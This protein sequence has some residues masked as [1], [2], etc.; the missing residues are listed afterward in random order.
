MRIGTADVVAFFSVLAA[1]CAE[2]PL[3]GPYRRYVPQVEE[4]GPSLVEM[5][6]T[7]LAAREPVLGP[8]YP[9]ILV[10]GFSGWSELG[11]VGYF[12][13]IED[14]LSEQGVDVYAPALPP[15]NVSDERARVLARVIDTVRAQTGK[16]KVHLVGHSQ[17]GIDIR[18]TVSAGGLG[19]ASKVASVTTVSTPYRGTAVADLA[20]A[21]PDGAL[22]AAGRLLAWLLG[23]GESAPPSEADWA[24][25]DIV[26][27]YDPDMAASTRA[28]TPAAM[29]ELMERSPWPREVPFFTVAGVSNLRSLDNED[30]VGGVWPRPDR[31]DVVDGFLS[32]SGSYLSFTDGGS[33]FSPR[34]NDGLVTVRS[35]RAPESTFLGCVPADHF[36]EMGQI[37][38]FGPGL[39]SGFDHRE[40][41]QRIVENLRAWE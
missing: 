3:Q 8:P 26:S 20:A 31:V 2:E 35:A 1:S 19:Y 41:Y 28:L 30:C 39:V 21:S 12:F 22:N 16:A 7:A 24:S 23:A 18:R 29:T 6:G 37:A 4:P 13:Q 25:D 5:A 10:H 14:L 32:G 40:L 17:G 36:D 15:Y 11:P 33:V 27:A 38:D 9:V 34:A